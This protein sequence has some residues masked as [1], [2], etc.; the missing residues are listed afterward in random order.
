M[1]SSNVA[2]NV[3]LLIDTIVRDT[4]VLIAQLATSGGLRAPLAHV[5]GQVFV[6]LAAELEREGVTKKVSADMFGL[7]LR[8]YQRRT[9]RLDPSQT[10][11]G[12]SLWEAVFDH[13][14]QNE[15]VTR[16]QVHERFRRDD[17]RSLRGVLRDLT[18]SGLV[19][20]SG[21]GSQVVYRMT[22]DDELTEMRRPDRAGVEAFVWS[23]IFRDG[24]ITLERLLE[25]TRLGREPLET[26][27]A[28]LV[29]G[30]RVEGVESADGTRYRSRELLLGFDDASGWEASVQDHFAAVVRTITR[31]LR[32]DARASRGDQ[33]GGSTYH[34]EIW[35]GHPLEEAVLGELRRFRER[36]SALRGEIDRH[37]RTVDVPARRLRVD[38]Y[39]G[40]SMLELDDHAAGKGARAKSVEPVEENA[41]DGD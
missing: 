21:R 12:R 36:M 2:M 9:Q 41:D 20:A 40:Q 34:F 31:K 38:A 28:A 35:H 6:E 14:A 19:F 15:I 7:A 8:T 4:T 37:N 18:E 13:I 24:P 16:D 29:D 22:T 5:A 32:L 30:G 27:L 11:R 39:Y 1:R 3:R 33:V 23:L 10:D 25:L 17:P 26:V